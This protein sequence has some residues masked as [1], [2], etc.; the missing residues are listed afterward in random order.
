M[1]ASQQQQQQGFRQILKKN[2]NEEKKLKLAWWL[3]HMKQYPLKV[4]FNL[5][6][7]H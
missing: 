5:F 3:G 6:S 1:R 4:I 2:L 7:F